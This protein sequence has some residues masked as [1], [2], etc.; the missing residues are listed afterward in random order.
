MDVI[1]PNLR[2]SLERDLAVCGGQLAV[3]GALAACCTQNEIAWSEK[4]RSS[5]L[6]EQLHLSA[7]SGGMTHGQKP[8]IVPNIQD[9]SIV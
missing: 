2:L 9:R 6:Q 7:W 3:S 1:F 8:E 4:P 5:W